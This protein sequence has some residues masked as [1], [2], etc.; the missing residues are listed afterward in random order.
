M[1]RILLGLFLFSITVSPIG[2]QAC[3]QPDDCR[4]FNS[5]SIE[6]R[7]EIVK[8]NSIDVN[9]ALTRCDYYTEGGPSIAVHPIVEAGEASI[10]FLLSKLKSV[11]EN[12]QDRA[13]SLIYSIDMRQVL[14]NRDEILASIAITVDRMKNDVTKKYCLERLNNMKKKA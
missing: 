3:G 5:H 10:P 9:F 6:E 14:L 1:I 4:A 11:D 7:K 13:I 12:E 8:K 2:W